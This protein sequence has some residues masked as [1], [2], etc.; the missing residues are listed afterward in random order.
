MMTTP[1]IYFALPVLNESKNLSGL[2]KCLKDQVYD[3]FNLVVCVNNY[4]HWWDLPDQIMK[5]EDN[6]QSIDYLKAIRDIEIM[7]IDRS[8]NG[9]GWPQKKGGVGWARKT[10]MDHIAEIAENQDLIVCIDADTFYPQNYISAIV[11][12]FLNDTQLIGLSIPY[13][14]KVDNDLTD[15]LILRYEIYMRTYLINML[16]IKNP[17]AFTALGS[18]MAVPVWAYKKAGGLTPFKSGEDFYFLQK[19]VKTG[20]LGLWTETIAYP[21]ARLSDRVLF[22]TGPALIKG[23]KGDWGSYPVYD[24]KLFDVIQTT[25][26]KFPEL[27]VQDIET[28]MDEFL[29]IQFRTNDIWGLLRKNYKDQPNFV[30]ACKSKVDGLRILQF[31]KQ[32]QSM[33]NKS[34][35]DCLEEN[36]NQFEL[37]TD[38][39]PFQSNLHNFSFADSSTTL[40]FEIRNHLFKLETVLRKKWQP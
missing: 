13:S 1:K 15:S 21:S 7:V 25:F 30:N 4:D 33:L 17:Y 38:S 28:P 12:T 11:D 40:L 34:D 29:K 32:A 6:Q 14:H 18:A 23:D 9:L 20:K 35:E 10:A 31:L 36:L 37:L 27:F 39:D 22:G 5:C 16:R 8:T 3:N 19:L 26:A 2:I 24:N